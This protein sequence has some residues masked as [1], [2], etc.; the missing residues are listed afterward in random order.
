MMQE[1]EKICDWLEL[2]SLQHL[3]ETL[4]PSTKEVGKFAPEKKQ[5][6]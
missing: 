3:K 1:V 6:K 4:T 2:A 5:K